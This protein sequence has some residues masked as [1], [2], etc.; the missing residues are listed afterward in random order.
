[1][2]IGI[3]VLYIVVV[4]QTFIKFMF[5]IRIYPS[6]GFTIRVL[7]KVLCDLQQFFI[8]TILYNALF[9]T[10]FSIL[11]PDIGDDYDELNPGIKWMLFAFR[12]ALHDFQVNKDGGF[13]V[14]LPEETDARVVDNFRF[15]MYLTW[16]VWIGNVV[17]MTILLFTFVVAV[18]G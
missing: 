14:N 3:K 2:E 10:L 6:I 13:L 17:L 12:N 16:L 15:T 1:M 9:A 7:S 11:S 18:V 4:I 8:F 5:L